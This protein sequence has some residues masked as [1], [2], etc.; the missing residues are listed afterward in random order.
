L[1]QRIGRPLRGF[2]FLIVSLG[3]FGRSAETVDFDKSKPGIAPADWTFPNTHSGEPG[4][5]LVHPD[6]TA[7]SKPNVLAQLTADKNRTHFAIAL[8]NR[9]HCTDGDLSVDLKMVSGK[10]EQTAGLIW[11]YQDPNNYY[12]LFVDANADKITV[13]KVIDGKS[14]PTVQTTG[15]GQISS[16]SRRVDPQEW[17][18]VKIVFRDARTAV[19]FNHRKVL[20]VE[21]TSIVRSGKTG[22]WTK[23]DTV[24]YFDDF[25]LDKKKE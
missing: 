11:R 3:W 19:F 7:P 12:L 21:D 13:H 6:T 22:V 14:S 9:G 25:R 18:V 10:L 16:A 17:N 4:R 8:F 15:T 20:E 23:G 24:A 1:S 5:W 2:A